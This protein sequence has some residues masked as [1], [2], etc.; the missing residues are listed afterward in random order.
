MAKPLKVKLLSRAKPSYWARYFDDPNQPVHGN[1]Q[2]I[3]DADATDYDWLIVYEQF[4]RGGR[5]GASEK[6]HCASENTLLLT[7]EPP[8]I[9][10]YPSV[11]TQQFGHVLTSHPED[12]LPH[13]SR[14]YSQPALKWF[15]GTNQQGGMS[16]AE[17]KRE[18]PS[19][20]EQL[21]TVCS[22]KQQGHTLHRRRYDF[23]QYLRGEVP[24][25]DV[26]GRGVR[27][28]DDKADALR[29]YRYHLAIENYLGQHHWTEKLSDS[30]PRPL[31]AAVLRLPQHDRLLPRGSRRSDRYRKP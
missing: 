1:C 29:P 10:R 7:T 12:T 22:S 5:F 31:P 15:Y 28:V 21:S 27:E 30:F 8:T 24:E 9:K 25:L 14:I 16:I 13:R 23:V 11:F 26:F 6:L 20:T 19:K 3:F 17:L 4:P 18:Q 2:F